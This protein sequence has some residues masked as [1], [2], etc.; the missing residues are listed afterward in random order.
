VTVLLGQVSRRSGRSGGPRTC[1]RVCES[2]YAPVRRAARQRVPF[3]QHAGEGAAVRRG[4]D[5][6]AAWLR[7]AALGG[8][9]V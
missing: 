9:A 4:R 6:Y 2:P 3:R 7:A 1:G 8:D 5:R